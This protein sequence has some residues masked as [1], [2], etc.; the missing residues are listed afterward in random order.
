MKGERNVL[1]F[2]YFHQHFWHKCQGQYAQHMGK[3]RK[4]KALVVLS[5]AKRK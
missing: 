2:F 1:P 5:Q 3:E 4:G